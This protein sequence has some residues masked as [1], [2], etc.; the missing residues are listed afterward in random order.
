MD[1][2]EALDLVTLAERA[3]E[4]GFQA[5]GSR[6]RRPNHRPG[7]S[8]VGEALLLSR[9]ERPSRTTSA[10]ARAGT[11]KATVSSEPGRRAAERRLASGTS[12][13]RRAAVQA[14]PGVALGDGRARAAPV[15]FSTRERA[16]ASVCSA[17][18]REPATLPALPERQRRSR[19]M[20]G[21]RAGAGH[22]EDEGAA[23]RTAAGRDLEGRAAGSNDRGRCEAG[24]RTVR[25]A[26]DASASAP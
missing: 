11:A 7:I 18:F 19:A 1:V 10:I 13:S 8:R 14:R 12:R 3:A 2:S 21:G 9:L 24:A 4:T 25:Q 26:A 6:A 5:R 17:V 22:R 15:A 23:R 16:S 20:Y